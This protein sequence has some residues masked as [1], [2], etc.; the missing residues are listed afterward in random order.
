MEPF[1]LIAG[2]EEVLAVFG[3][4]PSFHDGEVHRLLLDS[5]RTDE[6]GSRYPSIEL[7]LR[8]WNLT[9]QVSDEGFYKMECDSVVNLLFEHVYDL[10]LDGLNHQNVLSELELSEVQDPEKPDNRHLAI[11]LVHCYGLSGAFKAASARVVSIS[12]FKV[13]SAA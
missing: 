5:T 2:H 7:A 13:A 12:P 11:E 3:R 4:W 8:G 9:S 10:E 1:S 6:R